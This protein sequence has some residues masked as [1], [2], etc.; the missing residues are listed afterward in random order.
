MEEFFFIRSTVLW[1]EAP[2]NNRYVADIQMA[3]VGGTHCYCLLGWVIVSYKKFSGFV[4]FILSWSCRD[5]SPEPATRA[6]NEGSQRFH[7][8]GEGPYFSIIDS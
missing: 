8:H 7:N 5:L 4:S 1:V 2:M 3:R 6:A